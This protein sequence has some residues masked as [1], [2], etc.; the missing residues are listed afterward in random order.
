MTFNFEWIEGGIGANAV[1]VNNFPL[2]SELY[3]VE[4][5]W[6]K[7][8][9]VVCYVGGI[10]RIRGAFE[11]VGVIV[12]IG[13]RLMLAGDFEPGLE[14]QLKRLSG[15]RQV[16]AMGFIDRK[17]VRVTMA[18]SMAGL[19]VIHPTINYIDALPVKMF[20]YMSAGILVIA[21]NFPLWREI[22]EGTECGICVDPLNPEEIAE[23]IQ[24]IV[25]HP[26]ETEQMGK[27]GRRAVEGRYNWGMEDKKLLEFYSVFA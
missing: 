20:E 23:A 19:V 14:G 12:K 4:N 3:T 1:N 15:W 13:Y 5:Q 27:N 10:A 2:A 16:E 6:E 25:E 8:E 21:S 11:M 9:K 24:F 26:A 17:G 22:I 18:R 7:K